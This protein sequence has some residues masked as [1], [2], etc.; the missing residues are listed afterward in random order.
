M[1]RLTR[2]LLDFEKL[3]E[4]FDAAGTSFVSVTQS[5]NTTTSMGRLTLKMLL[6]LAQFEHAVTAERIR[7]KIAASEGMWMGGIPPLGYKPD[8]RSLATVEDHAAITRHIFQRYLALGDVR[9]LADELV[10]DRI[11][12]PERSTTTGKRMGGCTFSRG[13]LYLMLKWVTFT[14]QI[15]HQGKAYEGK[16][17]AIGDPD[18]FAS[19]Q[20]ML[21]DHTRGPRARGLGAS[22]RLLAGRIIDDD[23]TPMTSTHGTRTVSSHGGEGKARY[24]TMSAV[25][26]ITAPPPPACAS[27]LARSSGWG[28]TG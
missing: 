23:G 28:W 24:P 22:P 10:H 25:T 13:Q 2:S 1:D 14:G 21:A 20:A 12:S 26:C 5:F 17:P 15:G 18:T 6:S 27:P 11:L 7:G 9:R 16:H 19:V 8:G 4:A 3:V